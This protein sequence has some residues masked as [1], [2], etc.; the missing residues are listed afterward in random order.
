MSLRKSGKYIYQICALGFSQHPVSGSLVFKSTRFHDARECTMHKGI[1]VISTVAAWK[2]EYLRRPL[3]SELREPWILLLCDYR[4]LISLQK[5]TR[6]SPQ[7]QRIQ[8]HTQD[9]SFE[10]SIFNI[11]LSKSRIFFLVYNETSISRTH[12][13]FHVTFYDMACKHVKDI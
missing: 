11:F 2:I 1:T 7:R 3:F 12:L 9:I 4:I 13:S 10:F 8:N 6:H 5:P